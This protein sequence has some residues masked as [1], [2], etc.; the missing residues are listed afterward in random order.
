MQ[1]FEEVE[2]TIGNAVIVA[3]LVMASVLVVILCFTG[4]FAYAIA[5]GITRPVI[6]LLDIVSGLNRLDFYRHVRYGT[7]RRAIPGN[8]PG[9]CLECLSRREAYPSN[10]IF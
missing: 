3:S 10:G 1:V 8:K 6:Q 7:G 2:K 4:V 9:W 5:G